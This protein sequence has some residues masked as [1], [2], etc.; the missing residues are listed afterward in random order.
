M[1]QAYA[2]QE[3]PIMRDRPQLLKFAGLKSPS[4]Q[5]NHMSS[6]SQL[7]SVAGQN[8]TRDTSNTTAEKISGGINSIEMSDAVAV[9]E[10]TS[11]MQS[12]TNLHP[13]PSLPTI[14]PTQAPMILKKT[15]EELNSSKETASSLM[16]DS[17]K[18]RPLSTSLFSDSK[19]KHNSPFS[20][21]SFSGAHSLPRKVVQTDSAAGKS[22]PGEKVFPP[23]FSVSLS[24]PSS[25][26]ISPSVLPSSLSIASSNDQT[27]PF[28]I[29]KSMTNSDTK[30]DVNQAISTSSLALPSPVLPSSSF[31]ALKASAPPSSPSPTIYS[32][33]ESPKTEVKDS[34]KADADTATRAPAL[35][36]GSS[37]VEP[38]MKPKTSVSTTPV[39][40]TAAELQLSKSDVPTGNQVPG[41]IA[42]IATLSGASKGEFD[43]K[44]TPSAST[45]PK[46]KTTASA[47]VSQ[48]IFSNPVSAIPTMT[49]KSQPEQ[50]SSVP[51]LFPTQFPTSGGANGGGTENV[52]V[53]N[54]N[55]DDMDEE[56]PESSNATTELSLGNL[57]GFG[58]GS[59]P[60]PTAPKPNPFGVSFGNSTTNVATSPFTMN[61]S[62]GELFRPASFNFQSPQ[63]SQTS[64]PAN[65]GA[66]SG[67]FGTGTT[68]QA[69]TSGF[70]QPS[71]IGQGQQ[72]LGSVLGSFGQ[73]R[74]IGAG[75]PG[76]GLQ[77]TGFGSP[78]GFGG[79]FAAASSSGGLS[80]AVTGGG[81]ANI[82]ATAGGF[83]SLASSGSGFSSLASGAG[84][85]GSAA[86]GGGGFAAAASAGRGFAAAASP[87]VGFGGAASSGGFPVPVC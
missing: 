11:F 18:N 72:A 64:Q 47:S 52:D 42:T 49:L 36:L 24:A 9:R 65:T 71:Q 75:L 59:A 51:V 35:Q 73:S 50:P 63:A 84:G 23:T 48:P 46:L 81:F 79:G 19:G 66:F 22:Q 7:D 76:A 54:S 26:F 21:T 12:D 78:S 58:L 87:G 1:K 33:S 56:A 6:S 61:V 74:Q 16:V 28:F 3:T 29:A 5:R 32:I 57:G 40:K 41:T 69:P 44:I 8:N 68:A 14:F 70:G 77:G 13:K 39:T 62:S 82:S 10:N 83:A 17:A 34:S 60:N 15:S 25:P 55:E 4:L 31:E 27:A 86:S 30:A 20:H 80:S 67:G 43:M 2:N 53:S 37:K 38:D 85:F 45:T